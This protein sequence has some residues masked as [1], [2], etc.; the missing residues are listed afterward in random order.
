MSSNASNPSPLYLPP[1]GI[2]L[3]SRDVNI[4]DVNPV[5]HSFLVVAGLVHLHLFD[6]RL[7]VTSGKDSVHSAN[8]KHYKGEA[9]DLRIADLD[10]FFWAAFLLY[11]GVLA[12][13]F[14]L[15]IFDESNVPGAGHVH[16]EIAG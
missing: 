7:V 8:S 13:R 12:R 14:H 6:E 1:P 4:A 10:P 11:L 3:K 15:A 5:L 9:V 16:V 2:E